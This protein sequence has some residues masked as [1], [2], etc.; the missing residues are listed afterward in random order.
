MISN[1]TIRSVSTSFQR[2]A[3]TR[4]AGTRLAGAIA[5]AVMDALVLFLAASAGG[6]SGERT[7]ASAISAAAGWRA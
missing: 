1:M 5:V 6:D 7:V 2:R 4:A 3:V